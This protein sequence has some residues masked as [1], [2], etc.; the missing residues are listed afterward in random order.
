[1]I[2]YQPRERES[3]ECAPGAAR[4]KRR[5]PCEPSMSPGATSRLLVPCLKPPPRAS[6]KQEGPPPWA[7]EATERASAGV[8]RSGL[9][10]GRSRADPGPC[11]SGTGVPRRGACAL[12]GAAARLV[13]G[14][15]PHACSRRRPPKPSPSSSL[16]GGRRSRRHPPPQEPHAGWLVGQ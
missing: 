12:A 14:G 1:V 13:V 2:V 10:R 3:K 8:G 4:R 11:S 6:N 15:M 5:G 9:R 7:L 16:A